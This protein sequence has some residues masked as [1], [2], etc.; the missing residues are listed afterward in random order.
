MGTITKD[1]HNQCISSVT[2]SLSNK[3]IRINKSW[4][5][6]IFNFP[7]CLILRATKVQLQL[8]LNQHIVEILGKLYT[9]VNQ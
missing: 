4:F 1:L 8:Q 3:V 9:L 2:S 6:L 7:I 5:I